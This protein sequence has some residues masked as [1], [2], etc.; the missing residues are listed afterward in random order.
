ML[1]SRDQAMELLDRWKS[2]ST[3]VQVGFVPVLKPGGSPI[4]FSIHGRIAVVDSSGGP[5][6]ITPVSFIFSHCDV[7]IRALRWSRDSAL[8]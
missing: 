4:Q 6:S 3:R 2:L 7:R 5:D 8:A 1:L